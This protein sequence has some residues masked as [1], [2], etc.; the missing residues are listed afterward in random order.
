[1][2]KDAHAGTCSLQTLVKKDLDLDRALISNGSIKQGK[3]VIN[4]VSSIFF[5][6]YTFCEYSNVILLLIGLQKQIHVWFGATS[7]NTALLEGLN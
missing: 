3:G 2:V 1:M 6:N 5:Y 7:F 4:R